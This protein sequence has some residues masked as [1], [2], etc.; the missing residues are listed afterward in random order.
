MYGKY[1]YRPAVDVDIDD[2]ALL[3]EGEL[4]IVPLYKGMQFLEFLHTAP[5]IEF[6][7]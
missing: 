7:S 4:V 5:S 3:N 1:V 2:V 6:S